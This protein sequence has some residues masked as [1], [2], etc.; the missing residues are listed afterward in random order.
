[1]GLSID[2]ECQGRKNPK[3]GWMQF[4]DGVRSP[5]Q[6]VLPSSLELLL[7]GERIMMNCS[8]SS[9]TIKRSKGSPSFLYPEHR[10]K[11]VSTHRMGPWA[12]KITLLVTDR[13]A[14]LCTA[15]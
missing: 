6:G 2:Q 5:S 12:W 8:Y 11:C 15:P 9:E 3:S 4:W 14:P 13:L 10:G 7:V 1:M